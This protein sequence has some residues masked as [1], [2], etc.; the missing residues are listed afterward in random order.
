MPCI[1]CTKAINY[2]EDDSLE[3]SFCGVEAHF[4]CVSPEEVEI[5]V[6]EDVFFCSVCSDACN[7]LIDKPTQ[8]GMGV[9]VGI[10]STSK[11]WFISFE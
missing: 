8:E 3:C 2:G 9:I 1:G 4:D 6:H 5:Y 11:A 7:T 10:I